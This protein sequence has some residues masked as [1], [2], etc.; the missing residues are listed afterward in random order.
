[1]SNLDGEE[2]LKVAPE[3]LA[4]LAREAMRDIA[5]HLRPAHN[6]QVAK[7]LSDPEASDNDKVVARVLLENAVVASERKLPFCQDTGTATVVAK[8]GNRVLTDG[9]D[10]AHLS[11]GVFDTYTQES[12]R[13]SQT[14]ALDMYEE[15]NTGNNL[16]AQIDILAG[17]GAEYHFL[18]VAKGGGSATSR[19]SFRRPRR[20]STPRISR[21]SS[22]TR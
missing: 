3:G 19:R 15:K 6:E 2:L 20:C 18:F 4:L 16:P 10:V 1:V 12:M 21:P 14:A 5:F 7:I 9:D 8:K 22:S 11:R 17:H 13:Y